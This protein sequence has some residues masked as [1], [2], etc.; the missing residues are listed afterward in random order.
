MRVLSLF[1]AESTQTKVVALADLEEQTR[2]DTLEKLRQLGV[3]FEPP[4]VFHGSALLKGRNELGISPHDY[5][6]HVL[7]FD[8]EIPIVFDDG[9]GIIGSPELDS[10]ILD[11][12]VWPAKERCQIAP[13]TS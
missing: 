9:L 13:A 8:G 1:D 3:D 6:Q 2:I 12:I 7:R 4:F 10:L 5:L 11:T